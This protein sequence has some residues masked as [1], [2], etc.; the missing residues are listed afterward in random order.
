LTG[1]LPFDGDLREILIGHTQ[2]MPEPVRARNPSVPP[3]W[4]ALCARMMEKSREAR[5]Q[6]VADIAHALEDLRG[7]AAAYEAFR[8]ARERSGHSGRTLVATSVDDPIAS[9]STMHV[10][11]MVPEV[12]HAPVDPAAA[13]A[14]LVNDPRHSSFARTLMLQPPA[15]WLSVRE[16]AA[17][18]EVAVSGV[19]M[20]DAVVTWLAH[21][22]EA[23]SAV[24]VFLSPSTN[25]RAIA[26]SPRARW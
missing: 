5:F 10:D 1:T 23:S 14:A 24:I 8:S 17:A 6:S 11:L 25:W 13:C 12:E 2:L 18:A 21:P 19:V 4:E 26:V 20:S 7:H 15:R 3:E 9:R 22:G 16:L